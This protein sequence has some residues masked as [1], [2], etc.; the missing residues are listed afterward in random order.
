[1]A[2]WDQAYLEKVIAEKNNK[3]S[4]VP[5]T[6]VCK[7]FLDAVE[8]RVYGWFWECPNGESCQYRHC[9]PPGF[10]LRRDKERTEKF[11]KMEEQ[12]I[13]ETIDRER[14]LLCKKPNLTPITLATFQA[15]KKRKQEE[16]EKRLEDEI[17]KETKAVGG[18]AFHMLTG[19]A[20][21]KF[22]PR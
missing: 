15:W 17:K 3:G 12:L 4:L 21:F 11:E 20:L 2:D 1:M 8:N 14:E 6:I 5:S 13:E 18:K 9:L 16:R 19:R 22:D 10:V 7:Y